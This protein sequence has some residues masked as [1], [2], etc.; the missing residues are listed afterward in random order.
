MKNDL[1]DEARMSQENAL[2]EAFRQ[3]EE[4]IKSFHALLDTV[5]QDASSRP[6]SEEDLKS[7]FVASQ[8]L[9]DSASIYLDWGWHYLSRLYEVPNPH[10]PEDELLD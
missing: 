2:A 9:R 1:I 7:R 3:V 5:N 4:S 6:L 8:A 10:N